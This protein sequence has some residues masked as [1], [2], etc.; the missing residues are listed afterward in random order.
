MET[1]AETDVDCLVDTLPYIDSVYSDSPEPSPNRITDVSG[2]NGTSQTWFGDESTLSVTPQDQE[3]VKRSL[4]SAHEQD[5]VH[6][7]TPASSVAKSPD[8]LVQPCDEDT[9]HVDLHNGESVTLLTPLH[10]DNRQLDVG[11]RYLTEP[12]HGTNKETDQRETLA[13]FSSDGNKRNSG[14]SFSKSSPSDSDTFPNSK[15]V[16]HVTTPQ[17]SQIASPAGINTM[18]PQNR[19]SYGSQRSSMSSIASLSEGV[20][21]SAGEDNP[22]SPSDFSRALQLTCALKRMN[23]FNKGPS[24]Q[25]KEETHNS[26]KTAAPQR[27]LL[28]DGRQNSEQTTTKSPEPLNSSYVSGKQEGENNDQS[29]LNETGLELASG[30]NKAPEKE[31]KAASRLRSL[32]T[33]SK[34]PFWKKSKDGPGVSKADTPTCSKETDEEEGQLS[35][36]E[37]SQEF[38]ADTIAARSTN[39]DSEGQ[40][41]SALGT[42]ESSRHQQDSWDLDHEGVARKLGR[43]LEC[44]KEEVKQIILE[45][46]RLS[47]ENESTIEHEDSRPQFL[48]TSQNEEEE[49]E[50]GDRSTESGSISQG[51][52][53][54]Q[55][56]DGRPTIR[57]Q[58]PGGDVVLTRIDEKSSQSE[59]AD[60]GLRTSVHSGTSATDTTKPS[61]PQP[62]GPTVPD[63]LR[64]KR[65]VS[66]AIGG[67]VITILNEDTPAYKQG[68]GE[69]QSTKYDGGIATHHLASERKKSLLER[70][71]SLSC[72]KPRQDHEELHRTSSLPSDMKRKNRA[73]TCE[74][75][76]ASSC[77]LN[78]KESVGDNE[79]FC[80]EEHSGENN[81]SDEETPGQQNETK[82][83]GDLGATNNAFLESPTLSCSPTKSN[84]QL[85]PVSSEAIENS[86][87]SKTAHSGSFKLGT[88]RRERPAL[89]GWLSMDDAV[90][91]SS[92][93]AQAGSAESKKRRL[94]SDTA[95]QNVDLRPVLADL[96]EEDPDGE[97]GNQSEDGN[98]NV[99]EDTLSLEFFVPGKKKY[100]RLHRATFIAFV[101][102]Y[103]IFLSTFIFWASIL[104][105]K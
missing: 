56:S 82:K 50:T 51:K 93:L 45:L 67:K 26:V 36:H 54:E 43:D 75:G 91:E 52:R 71:L 64:G 86:R 85:P 17:E 23:N 19:F 16:P 13:M 47:S 2:D 59:S 34:S 104:L 27:F 84:D 18:S 44:S 21:E 62:P 28:D 87:F 53:S 20:G 49:V 6:Q 39:N 31:T 8:V 57:L 3:E 40:N 69:H 11:A 74:I 81:I 96:S 98:M 60:G 80:S 63:N 83:E 61:S 46:K 38:L 1:E 70:S 29:L 10:T 78:V 48:E 99:E 22:M 42:S 73:D 41:Q 25:E 101:L 97:S 65:H 76:T 33:K 32:F 103:S 72:D 102:K 92:P 77:E 100:I 7:E 30:E 68:H 66:F 35:S 15:S 105:F 90:S 88:D 14:S 94:Y 95:V 4:L 58:E 12:G 5:N 37:Y 79:G 24:V 9:E 89:K 55:H